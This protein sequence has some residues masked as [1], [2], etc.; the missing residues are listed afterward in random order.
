MPVFFLRIGSSIV[1]SFQFL[2][3]E[4]VHAHIRVRICAASS[5]I[6]TVCVCV[7]KYTWVLP[8]CSPVL[9]SERLRASAL[10]VAL[11][12][13]FVE[14]LNLSLKRALLPPCLQICFICRNK[15]F[16]QSL[17]CLCCFASPLHCSPT[18]NACCC[19][20]EYVQPSDMYWFH[21][22][23]RRR[24]ACSTKNIHVMW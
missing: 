10:G 14:S 1:S 16:M 12:R 20:R 24:W 5:C 17:W 2:S 8:E 19:V 22:S 21:F 3:P 18:V 9:S 15:A 7:F 6:C 13:A 23:C 4:I 11:C